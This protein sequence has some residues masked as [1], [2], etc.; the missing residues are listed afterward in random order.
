M[1]SS[2]ASCIMNTGDC[3]VHENSLPSHVNA[4]TIISTGKNEKL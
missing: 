1:W 2:T 3:N 4:H